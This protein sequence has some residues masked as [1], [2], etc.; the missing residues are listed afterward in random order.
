MMVFRTIK[1]RLVSILGAAAAGRYRVEGYQTQ[2]ESANAVSE[3]D[4]VVRVYYDQGSFDKQSSG[5]R[6]P[7]RH[8]MTFAISLI[9]SASATVDL[10]ILTDE[11]ASQL[12]I[13][14]AIAQTSDAN[15]RADASFD[16]LLEI[17][18]QILMDNRYIFL[19]DGDGDLDVTNRWIDGVDKEVLPPYGDKVTVA[20][21]IRFNVTAYED[22]DG[23]DFLDTEVD[24]SVDIGIPIMNEDGEADHDNLGVAVEE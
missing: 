22:V 13:A 8:D 12:A 10:S 14:A 15:Y 23:E 7:V 20:G 21:N 1:N 19:N 17:V 4:R 11:G 9:A 16:E 18:Y 24:G 6:G 2:R 3:N 5:Q